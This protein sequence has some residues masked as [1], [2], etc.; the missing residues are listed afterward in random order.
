[1][2]QQLPYQK[3]SGYTYDVEDFEP[4][5]CLPLPVPDPA[6]EEVGRSKRS[7]FYVPQ[8]QKNDVYS[9][10][11]VPERPRRFVRNGRSRF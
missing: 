4:Y 2:F 5:P 10:F 9:I 6:I 7:S 1:M 3:L 11:K 8:D